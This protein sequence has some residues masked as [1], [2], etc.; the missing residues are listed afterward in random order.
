MFTALRD[1]GVPADSPRVEATSATAREV[2]ML[3][4]LGQDETLN[5][6]CDAAD[7]LA[8]LQAAR[9]H[10]PAEDALGRRPLTVGRQHW[11]PRP[12]HFLADKLTALAEWAR[13]R[14]C[15]VYWC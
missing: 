7:F 12:P 5:D 10:L 2:L 13:A 14:G 8:R 11:G 3:L 4:G 15:A 1:R 9:G 6:S